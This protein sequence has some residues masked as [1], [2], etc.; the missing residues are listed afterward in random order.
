MSLFRNRRPEARKSDLDD[1]IAAHLA[2]AAADR[3]AAGADPATARRDARREFGNTALVKD[4]TRETWGDLWLEHLFADL[5]YSLRQIR[6]SPGFALTAIGTLALGIGAAAAMF[7][8]VDHVLLRPLPYADADRLVTLSERG[9]TSDFKRDVPWL[10]IEEWIARST[11]LEHFAFSTGMTGRNFLLGQTSTLQ[12]DG[13]AVSS[14]LFETL[15]AHPALGHGFRTE[16]PGYGAVKNANTIILS[17]AVWKTAFG[18]DRQILGRVVKVNDASY[19]VVGI[20]PPGFQYPFSN[21][22]NAQIWTTVALGASDRTRDYHAQNFQ[23]IAR[24]RHGATAQMAAVEMATIQRQV[25]PL[26]TDPETR[27][28]HTTVALERY[29]DS[30]VSVDIK[31]ALLSLLAAAGVLWLIASLNVINLLLARSI[32]RRREIAMRGALGASRWR[33][34]QQLLIEGLLLSGI[35]AVLGTGLALAAIRLTRSVASIHLNVDLSANLNVTILAALCG[36]TLLSA[37]LSSVWPALSAVRAPIEPA[38]KQ[39][40]QQTGASRH[41][42]RVRRLLVVTEIAMSLT[43]LVACGL[44]LRTIYTLRRV[45]LGY[46]TD[47]IVVANLA[48]PSWRYSGK[49]VI[50]NLYDPLLERVQHLHGVENAGLMSEVPLGQTFNI[51]LGLLMNGNQITAL[52]KPVTPQIQSIFGFRMLAGRFFNEQDTPTSAPAAVVNP[53]FAREYAPNKH[54]PS[55]L[56][57]MKVWNLRKDSPARVIGVL[58]N[59][60]QKSVAEPS[61][62]EVEICLCQLTPDSGVYQPSTIAVD[63]AVRTERPTAEM[64]PELRNI[65][66]QASPELADATITTMDQI[67]EDSYGSQRLAAHLLE[68]FGGS[69]LLLC[70]A[71]L[72]GLLAYI[73]SQR[74][75]EMGVRIALGAQRGNVLWLVLRQAG[76]MVIAGIV[77]GIL[78]AL[79]GGRFVRSYLYGVSTHDAWTLSLVALLLLLSGMLAAYLPARRAAGVNPVEALRAE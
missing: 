7:T 45:P 33:V 67:V 61:Q 72:Y 12:V 73:V 43:L 5:K 77:I 39:G 47:H 53:A 29:G 18:G 2:M 11:T 75:R 40:G 60:R 79:A 9:K 56:L 14:N 25:S 1:E 68:I 13:I 76:G 4:I 44:L 57:G 50:A 71:G 46:R 37:A 23:V 64:I 52:L 26:Y 58:D 19:T 6:K 78:L 55:S 69:A 15:G 21:F 63:L 54:D 48:I 36:L 41:Q 3:E 8:V 70:I 51:R 27:A 24:L 35:A 22:V 16:K 32:A 34:M 65:L 49:N 42:N 31:K 28:D 59:E 20:M 30:L 74:T 66:R 38:L 62:P 17:D 10:D